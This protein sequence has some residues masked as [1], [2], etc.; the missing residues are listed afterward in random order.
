MPEI[1]IKLIKITF[2]KKLY[3]LWKNALHFWNQHEKYFQKNIYLYDH[4]NACWSVLLLFAEWPS[5]CY[6]FFYLFIN[7]RKQE[8]IALER[9]EIEKQR[10]LLGKKKPN[11]NQPKG[12]GSS[13]NSLA[14]GD[15]IRPDNI[16]E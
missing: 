6:F 5:Y 9:E 10:K 12:R 15:F 4:Q 2:K 13:S 11:A 7:Y 1:G 14:N 8:Q 16:K 3:V